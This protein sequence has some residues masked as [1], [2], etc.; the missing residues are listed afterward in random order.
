[1]GNRRLNVM[2]HDN[3]Q[4]ASLA[5]RLAVL[6]ETIARLRAG[7]S[8]GGNLPPVSALAGGRDAADQFLEPLLAAHSGEI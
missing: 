8:H 1:M 5:A 6:C 3:R 4:T 7:N 2:G